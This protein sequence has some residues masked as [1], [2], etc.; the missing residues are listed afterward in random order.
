M[1]E[2]A[3]QD[4]EKKAE[5]KEGVKVL[6]RDVTLTHAEAEATAQSFRDLHAKHEARKKEKKKDHEQ[7]ES[8]ST[9]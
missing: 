9:G 1:T 5:H 7:D 4:E 6:R 3:A 2:K 8:S